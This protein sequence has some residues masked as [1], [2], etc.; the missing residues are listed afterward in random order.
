LSAL[1]AGI[2][3]VGILPGAGFGDFGLQL[4]EHRVAAAAPLK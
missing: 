2:L 4:V 3:A 1:V